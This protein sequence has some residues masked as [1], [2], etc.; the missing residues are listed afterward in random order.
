LVEVVG[1]PEI[2]P[3]LDTLKPVGNDPAVKLQVIGVSPTVVE[4]LLL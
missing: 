2:T 3:E 4:R 1:V